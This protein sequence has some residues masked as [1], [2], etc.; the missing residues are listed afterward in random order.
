MTVE[1]ENELSTLTNTERENTQ[2][3]MSHSE[4]SLPRMSARERKLPVT[5]TNDFLW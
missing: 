4:G 3:D 2:A 5:S 1:E